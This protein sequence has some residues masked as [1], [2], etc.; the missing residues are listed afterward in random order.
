MKMM[1]KMMKTM[2][3]SE[4]LEELQICPASPDYAYCRK[5]QK[6]SLVSLTL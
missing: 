5:P 3:R 1:V 6:R 2:V 4:P